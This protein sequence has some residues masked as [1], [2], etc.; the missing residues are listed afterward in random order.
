MAAHSGAASGNFWAS[1]ASSSTAASSSAPQYPNFDT[2]LIQFSSGFLA[3]LNQLARD[4]VP[5]DIAHLLPSPPA[6]PPSVSATASPETSSHVAVSAAQGFREALA[7]STLARDPHSQSLPRTGCLSANHIRAI[8]KKQDELDD[9][10][11]LSPAGVVHFLFADLSPSSAEAAELR[12]IQRPPWM[13]QSFDST[14]VYPNSPTA[15]HVSLSPQSILRI[16]PLLNSKGMHP[17]LTNGLLSQTIKHGFPEAL[18]AALLRAIYRSALPV[19]EYTVL[20]QNLSLVEKCCAFL[21]GE[22]DHVN[23]IDILTK[24]ASI[25]SSSVFGPGD[26]SK[27]L[28]SLEFTLPFALDQSTAA[29]VCRA[30]DLFL[31]FVTGK[32]QV[33]SDFFKVQGRFALSSLVSTA[34]KHLFTTAL[35]PPTFVRYSIVVRDVLQTLQE[36]SRRGHG[37][38][39][40][41]NIA[42]LVGLDFFA[43]SFLE[44]A[45]SNR[46]PS[47]R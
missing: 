44:D 30:F 33:F 11:S 21:R 43:S 7:G 29:F 10:R 24:V 2:W 32:V 27:P 20:L 5:S 6:F 17:L 41:F 25:T 36:R 28:A 34:N 35:G 16:F 42:N 13:N 23:I 40:E 4:A 18:A 39:S 1:F 22:F 3:N 37:D 14:D 47:R 9:V 26:A 8:L 12:T 46:P 45:K 19:A 15:S 31:Q 38:H